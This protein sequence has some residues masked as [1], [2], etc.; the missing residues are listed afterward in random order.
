LRPTAAR[1]I[2]ECVNWLDLAVVRAAVYDARRQM[3]EGRS[4]VEAVAL[5]CREAW[6]EYSGLVRFAVENCVDFPPPMPAARSSQRYWSIW[7]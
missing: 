7:S 2:P 4:S 1:L 3:A 5:V 6:A